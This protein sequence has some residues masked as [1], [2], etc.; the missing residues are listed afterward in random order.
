MAVMSYSGC[1][2]GIVPSSAGEKCV[3]TVRSAA[4]QVAARAND[5]LTAT[6]LPNVVKCASCTGALTR[7]LIF[8]KMSCTSGW[9]MRSTNVVL[10][11]EDPQSDGVEACDG[12]S[13]EDPQSV[14]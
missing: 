10:M 9:L 4:L 1:S 14:E 5:I 8:T 12:G 6:V 7:Q 11:F 13:F 2:D 3:I